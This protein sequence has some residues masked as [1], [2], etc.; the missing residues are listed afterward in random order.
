MIPNGNILYVAPHGLG[1]LIMSLPAIELILDNGYRLTVL[2][3]SNSERQYLEHTTNHQQFEI[4]V[5]DEYRNLGLLSGMTRLFWKLLSSRFIAAINSW[6]RLFSSVMEATVFM[7]MRDS[8]T[9]PAADFLSTFVSSTS[10]SSSPMYILISISAPKAIK[11]II[12]K[13]P[14]ANGHI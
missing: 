13:V 5:L 11:G 8:I 12:P 1:D 4:L 6:H 9:I 14:K 3:K 10:P 7:L 2:V